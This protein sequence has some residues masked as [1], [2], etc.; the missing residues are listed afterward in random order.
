LPG[1]AYPSGV[2]NEE[3]SDASAFASSFAKLE[4]RA[5][6]EIKADVRILQRAYQTIHDNPTRAIAA[7]LSAGAAEDHVKSWTNTH[8]EE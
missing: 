2:F 8:C 1:S 5:P 3:L 7:S 6:T 4:K